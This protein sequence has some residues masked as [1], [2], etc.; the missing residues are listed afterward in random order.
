VGIEIGIELPSDGTLLEHAQHELQAAV[1]RR[2][3]GNWAVSVTL[4]PAVRKDHRPSLIGEAE[5]LCEPYEFWFFLWNQGCITLSG[6]READ[7]AV[8]APRSEALIYPH[9]E[10]RQ[11]SRFFRVL[12]ANR[13]V[14]VLREHYWRDVRVRSLATNERHVADATDRVPA[15]PTPVGA[16]ATSPLPAL[17]DLA[18]LPDPEARVEVFRALYRRDPTLGKLKDL[19][20]A[21]PKQKYFGNCLD[22]RPSLFLEATDRQLRQ[23]LTD[24]NRNRVGSKPSGK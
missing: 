23:A 13:L 18:E 14:F 10:R 12:G 3:G 1:T 2:I 19:I 8:I 15:T 24:F 6:L 21:I 16:T 5:G 9:H 4:Y 11:D 7:D 17:A 22:A 20:T